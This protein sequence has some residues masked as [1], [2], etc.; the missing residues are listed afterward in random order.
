MKWLVHCYTHWDHILTW[1][2]C[3]STS[4]ETVHSPPE[5]TLCEENEP[6]VVW[7]EDAANRIPHPL[8][9]LTLLIHWGWAL[10]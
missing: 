4:P 1:H 2:L 8:R 7:T 9:P 3:H 6:W 10:V 5:N